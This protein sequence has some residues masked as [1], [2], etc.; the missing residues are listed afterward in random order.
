MAALKRNL[1]LVW[2]ETTNGK[3]ATR[4]YYSR[5]LNGGTGWGVYDAQAQRFLKDREV[6]AL[7]AD[8]LRQAW[9]N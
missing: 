4:R 5:S 7:T 9:A 3:G 2:D 1:R 8:Q 6:A